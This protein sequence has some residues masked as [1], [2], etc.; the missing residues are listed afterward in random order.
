MFCTQ[1]GTQVDAE[2]NFC[3]N[4]GARVGP[5]R[6]APAKTAEPFASTVIARE[7]TRRAADSAGAVTAHARHDAPFKEGVSSRTLVIVAVLVLVLVG[8]G[9]HFITGGGS[10]P[11]EPVLSP[12]APAQE[13]LASEA[14]A[15]EPLP[16]LP[17][18]KEP[19]AA[20][21]SPAI[22]P[23]LDREPDPAAETTIETAPKT[24][25]D[26]LAPPSKLQPQKAGPDSARGR[27]SAKALA[28]GGGAHPGTY[29]TVRNT[30]VHED[31]SASSGVIATIPV[32]VR[33]NV[34]G[35][36]GD[37]LEVHSRRGNPPG[38]IRRGDAVFLDTPN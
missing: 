14:P 32:G 38:F 31:P 22:S 34:V 33:V 18:S 1:C 27:R 5:G 3:K 6:V 12:S 19:R 20:A 21:E 7:N 36:T 10:K 9:A 29:E 16:S 25:P 37:W 11:A 17:K 8:A 26:V 24:S 35:S 28:P 15:S 30:P 4:C 13:P 23:K 2:A